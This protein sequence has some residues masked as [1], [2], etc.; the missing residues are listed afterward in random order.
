M[1]Y[2]LP[3]EDRLHFAEVQRDRYER[4]PQFRLRQINRMRRRRGMP[5]IEDLSEINSRGRF[6][7][8]Q[9]AGRAKQVRPVVT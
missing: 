5:L 4:D 8:P 9:G 6:S 7:N 3:Y 2:T 1:A